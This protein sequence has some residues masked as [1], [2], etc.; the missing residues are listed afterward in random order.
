MTADGGVTGSENARRIQKPQEPAT[1][2]SR[3][4]K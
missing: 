2:L 3:Y 4:E 1:Y